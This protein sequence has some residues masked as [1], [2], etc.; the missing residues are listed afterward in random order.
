MS[1]RTIDLK[2]TDNDRR[3]PLYVFFTANL[4]QIGGCPDGT[5]IPSGRSIWVVLPL[6]FG[7]AGQLDRIDSWK[8]DL[9]R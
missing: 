8:T 5:A 7:A 4:Q 3:L 1:R 2:D 6:A 9:N